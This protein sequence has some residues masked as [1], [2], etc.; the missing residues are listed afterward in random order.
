MPKSAAVA[1]FKQ[2]EIYEP[3]RAVL[4]RNSAKPVSTTIRQPNATAAQG[5]ATTV[6]S[7]S[8]FP[9]LGD[10]FTAIPS[11]T[12]G[13]V[14]PR[15]VV[16][17]LNTQV[18]IQ[19]RPGVAEANFPITLNAFWSPLGAFTDTFDPRILYDT[20]PDRWM[21]AA[22]VNGDRSPRR[23]AGC[24]ADRRPHGEV[25]L[26]Q[27]QRRRQQPMG[28]TSLPWASTPTER[29]QRRYQSRWSHHGG[30][31]RTYVYRFSATTPGNASPA[32]NSSDAPPPVDTCEILSDTPAALIAFSESP[33]PTTLV[34]PD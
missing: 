30:A 2:R 16:T 21:A 19:S 27:N 26:L 10:N 18:L 5:A 24:D 6:P 15:H 17:M 11:D 28:A 3:E 1:G 13:A 12:Q 8:G 33:P 4:R 7:L 20:S 25:E 31:L 14:G 29:R 34:A 23:S 32:R 22:A 9:G